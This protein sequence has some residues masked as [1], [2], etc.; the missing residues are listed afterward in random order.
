MDKTIKKIIPLPKD[1]SKTYTH[2]TLV[3]TPKTL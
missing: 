2:K 3:Q 1:I